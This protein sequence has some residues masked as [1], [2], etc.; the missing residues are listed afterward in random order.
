MAARPALPTAREVTPLR[1]PYLQDHMTVAWCMAKL[2]FLAAAPLV[3][4]IISHMQQAGNLQV[5][6]RLPCALPCSA[7]QTKPPLEPCIAGSN[8]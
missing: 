3:E 2:G 5:Q 8:C 7:Q 1:M 6:H 4:A